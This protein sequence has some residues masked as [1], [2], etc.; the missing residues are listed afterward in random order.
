MEPLEKV[1]TK[2]DAGE[3]KPSQNLREMSVVMPKSSPALLSFFAPLSKKPDPSAPNDLELS[4]PPLR[5]LK[6]MGHTCYLSASL[7]MLFRAL[8]S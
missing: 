6:N 7:Q 4:A 3:L 2:Y 5:G 1:E 8:I